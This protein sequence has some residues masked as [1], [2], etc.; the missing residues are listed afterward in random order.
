[1]F[2]PRLHRWEGFGNVC[3]SWQ[4]LKLE[5]K[6]LEQ[7]RA[8]GRSRIMTTQSWTK[9]SIIMNFWNLLP[10]FEVFDSFC[11]PRFI[12]FTTRDWSKPTWPSIQDNP[13]LV[14]K[15]Y[16]FSDVRHELMFSR[17]FFFHC[18]VQI[19]WRPGTSKF[20]LKNARPLMKSSNFN[21]SPSRW[22]SVNCRR[23]SRVCANETSW[24]LHS[25]SSQNCRALSYPSKH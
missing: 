9:S 20:K 22:R 3:Y 8:S 25:T 24:P 2:S 21:P 12:A 15:M 5:V 23:A 11:L 7:R 19:Y 10:F 6:F 16:G 17:F 1:M 18:L 4:C 14:E 13:F